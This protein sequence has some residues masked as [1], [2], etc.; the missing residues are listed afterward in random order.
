MTELNASTLS[1]LPPKVATPSHDRG[2]LKRG[3]AHFG[4]GNFHRAHQAFCID[5]CLD[6]PGQEDW[7]IVGIGVSGGERGRQK[8]AQYRTQ[9]CLYS[10]TIAPPHG[11]PAMLVIG[12]QLDYLLAP[13]QPDEVL[14]LLTSP[15]LRISRCPSPRAAITSIRTRTRSSPTTRTSPTT[16]PATARRVRCSASS[17]RP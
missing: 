12:A 14:A 5:R 9:D 2:R 7:G 8:A 6:L 1:R 17:P 13:E 10:L 16:S 15:D 4:V 11:E 3:I